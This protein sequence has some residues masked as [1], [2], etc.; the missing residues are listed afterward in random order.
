MKW[1]HEEKARMQESARGGARAAGWPSAQR[2]QKAREQ[3]KWPQG[4]LVKSRKKTMAARRNGRRLR[5]GRRRKQ[6]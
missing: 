6:I 3:G 5:P 4:R 1:G 2:G